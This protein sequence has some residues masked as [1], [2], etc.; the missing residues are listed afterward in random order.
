MYALKRIVAYVIDYAIVFSIVG[1]LMSLI[2]AAFAK[3]LQYENL[4]PILSYGMS[5]I[6][7][8][9]P[10]VILG[11]LTGHFGRTPGKLILSLR[12][13]DSS[14]RT[15]GIAR[16]ILREVIKLITFSFFFGAIWAL[17]GIITSE[18]AFYD[19]WLGCTV[20]DLRPSGLTETQKKWRQYMKSKS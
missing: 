15:L 7:F 1:F 17:Y 8:G 5:A 4:A 9:I 18:R 3:Y 11:A 12:V 13:A 16:G 19:D 20:E 10:V 2:G 6:T 14:G